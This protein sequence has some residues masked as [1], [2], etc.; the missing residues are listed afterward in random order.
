MSVPAEPTYCDIVSLTQEG[1][2]QSFL[3]GRDRATVQQLITSLDE[4]FHSSSEG[5]G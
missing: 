5:E 2:R 1:A 3:G 4:C